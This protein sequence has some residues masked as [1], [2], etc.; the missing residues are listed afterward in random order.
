[1]QDNENL[2][3]SLIK[4]LNKLN[5]NSTLS[6]PID[7]NANIKTVLSVDSYLLDYKA[8]CGSGKAIING[9]VGVKIVYIDTDN[10]T[11]TI[12]STQNFS[13]TYLDPSIT[14][15]C[16]LNTSKYS[17]ENNILSSSGVLKINCNVTISPI[18]Y[19]NLGFN[20]NLNA[21]N[22][23][24]TKT[25]SIQS[26]TISN[27]INSQF[28]NSNIIEIENNVSKILAIQSYAILENTTPNNN[29]ITLEGKIVCKMLYEVLGNDEQCQK[30]ACETFRFK[31]DIEQNN[32]S[33]LD[34]LD[35]CLYVD[36]S[37]ES[38]QTETENNSTIV[39]IKNNI[40]VKGVNLRKIDLE[41]C[42]DLFCT[43]CDVEAN[44][45]K[46]EAT[47]LS[48]NHN[49]SEVIFNELTIPANEP[50]IDSV[51]ANLNTNPEITNTYIKNGT[52][53]VE[54]VISSNIIYIDENKTIQSK[55]IESPFVINTKI[56]KENLDGVNSTISV[57]DSKTKVKRGTII[58]M[59]YSIF[60]N[61]T[62]HTKST[63]EIIDNFKLGKPFTNNFDYQ[64]FIAKPNET[65]WDLSK[66]I[67]ISP[68]E[69]VTTNKT[70]PEIMNGGERVIIK[71][72]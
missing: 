72:N 11:N 68:N 44:K 3:I 38:F 47:V 54:G 31:T 42:D 55:T 1:M 43:T 64:I 41:I 25:K 17:I 27:I 30:F 57:I 24:I 14:S 33:E 71:R 28:E 21:D 56:E 58:E 6:I 37:T 48:E 52:V 5:F 7:S 32:I 22:S 35:L 29:S 39:T 9:K 26:Y 70:L 46:R 19:F 45:T 69:L 65:I 8:E 18:A 50:A 10:F 12:S 40:F 67:K 53:F 62:I 61:M 60:I 15:D 63:I 20:N 34:I 2:K 13:E 66:R 49:I 51:I 4:N 16:Y 36:K 59:E 23:I